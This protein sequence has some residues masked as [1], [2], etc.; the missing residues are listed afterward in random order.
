MDAARVAIVSKLADLEKAF[1][2]ALQALFTGAR[3]ATAVASAATRGG[4]AQLH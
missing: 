1:K 3:L 4:G 2:S